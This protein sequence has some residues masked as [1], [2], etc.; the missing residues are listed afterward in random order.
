MRNLLTTGS[1]CASHL[2]LHTAAAPLLAAG[3]AA[4][5]AV[6]AAAAAP[7]AAAEMAVGLQGELQALDQD[8]AAAEASLQAA[9]IRLGAAAGQP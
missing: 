7:A 3:A 4:A 6:S 9:V 1:V 8:I 2:Q 5:R